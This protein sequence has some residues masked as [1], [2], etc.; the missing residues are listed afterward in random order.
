MRRSIVTLLL[1]VGLGAG[2]FAALPAAL[3]A[4]PY[5][6]TGPYVGGLVGGGWGTAN[7]TNST[8]FV[9]G[10]AELGP[11]EVA[12]FNAG[13]PQNLNPSAFLAGLEAGYD[14]QRYIFVL[15]I[16]GDIDWFNLNAATTTGPFA[17]AP[18][19]NATITSSE[20]A[21]WLATVRGRIGVAPGNWLLYATGGAA[22][23]RLNANFSV[24]VPA[25]VPAITETASFSGTKV[26]YAVGGGVEV[27]MAPDWSIKGEYLF[28]DFGSLSASGSSGLPAQPFNH[29][30]NLQFNIARFGLNYHF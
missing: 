15:G 22:F 28:V 1:A 24:S 29:T 10:G 25:V 30:L 23:S 20:N 9:G 11:G 8:V 26:G 4:P 6:W 12:A 7:A 27:R 19:V 3:A 14:W 5:D 18:G 2:T 21:N 13:G 17:L 16:E